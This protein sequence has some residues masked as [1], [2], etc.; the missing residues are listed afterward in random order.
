[1]KLRVSATLTTIEPLRG[2]MSLYCPSGI[3][4]WRPETV[5]EKRRVREP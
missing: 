5:W 4:T 3:L 1:M 2:L